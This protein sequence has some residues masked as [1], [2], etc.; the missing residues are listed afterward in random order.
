MTD[1]PRSR[2]IPKEEVAK[3]LEESRSRC[4]LCRV[5]IDPERDD[6]ETLFDTLEKHHIIL[7]S[8]GGEHTVE[9]LLLVC[10]NCHTKMGVYPKL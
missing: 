1:K 6:P 7:F 8:E 10:A 3:L 5:L 2:H 9:N 4:C